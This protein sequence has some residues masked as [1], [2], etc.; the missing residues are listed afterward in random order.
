[1]KNRHVLA[2]LI[3]FSFVAIV[4][5]YFSRHTG[6]STPLVPGE[7]EV[8]LITLRPA[9]FEPFEITRPKDPFVLFI[10]DRSGKETSL[11][12]KPLKGERLRAI[13]LNRKKSEWHDVLNL[14]PGT[15]VLQDANN[16]ELRCQITI[17]P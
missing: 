16:P 12:L 14:S 6:A 3:G 4:L 9:G 5:V 15:Y 10:D 1:M 17:L 7:L 11:V 13:S 2:I 8:E